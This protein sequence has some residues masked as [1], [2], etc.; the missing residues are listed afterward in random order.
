MAVA[1]AP[2]AAATPAQS[3]LSGEGILR[4]HCHLFLQL[5]QLRCECLQAWHACLL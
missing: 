3:A 5:P 1:A 4:R 2:V